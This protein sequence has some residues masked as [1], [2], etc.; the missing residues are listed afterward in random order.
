MCKQF[1]FHEMPTTSKLEVKVDR[2]K[3]GLSKWLILYYFTFFLSL[4]FV[5]QILVHRLTQE[6]HITKLMHTYIKYVIDRLQNELSN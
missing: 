5:I 3:C 2:I 4:S 1:G 6:F